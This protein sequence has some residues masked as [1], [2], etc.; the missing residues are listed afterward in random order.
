MSKTF[1]LIAAM[2]SN[3]E[4]GLAGRMP[5][6]LPSELQFFKRATMGKSIVMGRKTWQAIG[7]PLPGRQNI[8]ISRNP[9][10]PAKGV[11]LVA[12][13]DRAV[14][15]SES[16]EIMV[17]GGGQLYALALPLAQRMILTLIDIEPEADT[18]FPEWNQ[19]EW[20]QTG[21][22]YFPAD[23]NNELAYRIIEFK[24]ISR[25]PG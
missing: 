3:R 4:I 10:L 19:S 25:Q 1:T 11:D 6:H 12:S 20:A 21:E 24:R 9:A 18:W 14:E 2:G 16:D 8:V 22:K 17:I 23:E 7:R 15:I 5:W 13:L